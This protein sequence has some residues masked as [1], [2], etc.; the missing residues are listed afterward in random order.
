MFIIL[1]ESKSRTICYKR[2]YQTSTFE[3]R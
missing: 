2:D 1:E 3:D